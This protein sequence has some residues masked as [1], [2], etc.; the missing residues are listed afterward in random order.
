[1]AILLPEI[2]ESRRLA[3]LLV[4]QAR[5]QMAKGE[6]DKAVHTLQTGYALGRHVAEGP[7]IVNA[8]VGM[9]ICGIMSDQLELLIQQPGSPNLY[10][11]LT[12]LPQPIVSLRKAAEAEMNMLLVVVPDLRDIVGKAR[13]PAYWQMFGDRV[14]EFSGVGRPIPKLGHQP[15]PT[16]LAIKGYPQAKRAL[17]EQGHSRRGG[18]RHARRPGCL[19][20]AFG[21]TTNFATALFKWFRCPIGKPGRG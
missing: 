11:A 17:I 20:I 18:R 2:Q 12:T 21:R 8:L 6:Y 9:A 1:M 19:C 5:L 10:W 7:T 14:E 4:V 16:A 13:D 3:R 15:S